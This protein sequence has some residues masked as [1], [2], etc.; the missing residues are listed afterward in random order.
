MIF[1]NEVLQNVSS[2]NITSP[3]GERTLLGVKNFHNGID[4]TPVSYALAFDGGF[5]KEVRRDIKESQTAEIIAK[6]QWQ[7][8]SGNY[9]II[10]H[11]DNTETIYE[12]LAY[13]SV[14]VNVGEYVWK[15][16]KIGKA[17]KTGFTTGSHLHF[18]VKVNNIWVDPLPY[19]LGK[20]VIRAIMNITRPKLPT[21]EVMATSLNY[22]DQPNGNVVN[23]LPKGSYAYLGRSE[24]VGGYQWA[25]IMYLGKLVYC[26]LNPAWNTV[27]EVIEEK[28]QFP[29][30][31]SQGGLTVT[32]KEN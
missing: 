32:I 1:V 20:K 22:R 8:Y 23:T 21:L 15:K 9:V 12:H 2:Y 19:L 3:F 27:H 25:E 7:L 14:L 31:I 17:G 11:A 24:T 26:A 4:L 28:H 5:V 10:Q 6:K 13:G 16:T 30:I 29:I 18:G